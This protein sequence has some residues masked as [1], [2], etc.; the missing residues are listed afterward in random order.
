ML[1]IVTIKNLIQSKHL[2][3]DQKRRGMTLLECMV[4]MIMLSTSFALVLQFQSRT[5]EA[6]YAQSTQTKVI[7]A[8][9][10]AR[11]RIGAWNLDEITADSIQSMP[12]NE[13]LISDDEHP[14]WV[15]S[16]VEVEEPIKGKK[17]SIGIQ[18]ERHQVGPK[19]SPSSLSP[20]ES[21]YKLEFWVP[22]QDRQTEKSQ[23]PKNQLIDKETSNE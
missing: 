5:L 20:R 19:Q 12:I 21:I 7:L 23:K 13:E 18:L 4:A 3:C 16:V 6:H 1:W 9:V 2:S 15:A 8:I 11:E 10:S 17:V 14:Q 22:Q